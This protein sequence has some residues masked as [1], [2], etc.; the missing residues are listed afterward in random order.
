V[1]VRYA[2]ALNAFNSIKA[3]YNPNSEM[4][5]KQILES[6]ILPELLILDEVGIQFG[7]ETEKILIYQMINGRYEEVMPTIMISNYTEN[8]LIDYIGLRCM[9]RMKEGGGVVVPFD[10]GSYR[11]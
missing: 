11:R 7:T 4:T 1:Q 3:T 10:W 9:D 2:S 5:E 8:D 6:F